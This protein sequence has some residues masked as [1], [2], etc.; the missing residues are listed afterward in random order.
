[1]LIQAQFST[2]QAVA[3]RRPRAESTEF[4]WSLQVLRFVAAMMVVHVALV[5]PAIVS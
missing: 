5:W 1:M 2:G 4:V 3:V